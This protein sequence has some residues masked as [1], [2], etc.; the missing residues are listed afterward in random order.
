MQ[1]CLF[2]KF[3]NPLECIARYAGR[4]CLIQHV[5]LNFLLR[6]FIALAM[7]KLCTET[8]D[9]SL[10]TIMRHMRGFAFEVFVQERRQLSW[11]CR[12]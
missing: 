7:Q 12:K 11:K 3:V 5:S 10:S 6:S 4:I 1:E 8:D 2:E 9:E